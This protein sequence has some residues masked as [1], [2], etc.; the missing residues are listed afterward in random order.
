MRCDHL[1]FAMPTFRYAG[2]HLDR[3]GAQRGDAAWLERMLDHPRAIAIPI[4]RDKT[5]IESVA[6]TAP[7]AL[8]LAVG[9]LRECLADPAAPPVFLGSSGEAPCFLFDV[10]IL[11]ETQLAEQF[12]AG[13]FIDLRRVGSLLSAEDAALAAYARGMAGWQRRSRFCGTCG[14]PTETTNGGHERR[15]TNISCGLATYPRTDP[16]VIMLVEH[17]PP[18]GGEPRCLLGRH[19]RLP[20]SVYS[21]LAGFVEPG[22]SLEETVARETLE[23][24]GVRVR[25]V[26]YFGSQPWPFPASLMIGFRA[27]AVSDEILLNDRELEDARWFTAREVA[28]FGEWEDSDA[29]I[30]LPRRDSIA[31]ALIEDWVKE[32]SS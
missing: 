1:L 19:S 16:A 18:N 10:S 3:A 21:T 24:A 26:R 29:A 32:V 6:G 8:T 17:R 22:E 23:E 11:E 9:R 31:R 27:T 30:R 12:G 28:G 20:T 14:S 2:S 15:C 4:W 7:R 13:E 5:L 25:D